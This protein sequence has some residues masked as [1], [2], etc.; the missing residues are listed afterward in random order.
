MIQQKIYEFGPYSLDPVQ[1]LLRRAGSVVPLQPRALEMLLALLKQRGEVVSKQELMERVWPDSFVEEGNLT[2]NIFLLRR[3]LGKTLEGEEYIQTVPK[4]GYRMN[5]PVQESSRNGEMEIPSAGSAG[6]G[7]AETPRIS[8]ATGLAKGTSGTLADWPVLAMLVVLALGIGAI[9]LWQISSAQPKVSGYVRITHDG[10]MKRGK[11]DHVGGP[12]AAL[13]ADGSRIYFM[14]GSADAPIIAEV[15]ATGGETGRLAIPFSLPEL[16]DFSAVGSELLVGGTVDEAS[17]M[18][19]WAVPVPAGTAHRLGAIVAWDASW[20]PDGHEIAYSRG[21]ELYLAK[22]DGSNQKL[23][24]TLP[25]LGWQPRWSPD[26]LRLRFTVFDVPTSITSLWEVSREGTGLHPLL[27][28]WNAG[29]RGDAG[30]V[31]DPISLCCG[32]WTPDGRYFVFQMT[33]EAAR[34]SGRCLANRRSSAVFFRRSPL[35]FGSRAASS[36]PRRP[37]LVPTDGGFSSSASSCA[38]S[39]SGTIT[40]TVSSYLGSAASQRALSTSH[41]MA[42]GSLMLPILKALCG[43]A[44]WMAASSCNSPLLP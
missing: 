12:D 14:E 23:L 41:A 15:S 16:M 19:L 42:S 4:R 28:G 22:S 32:S 30:L 37:F 2:Q 35:R 3:E 5:V 43:A 26:G 9:V 27:P 20:S 36:A 38:G 44:A 7:N 10:S 17:P 8:A 31:D 24:A 18:P 33:G 13:F 25:G 34:T 39:L 40:A 21:R 11:A 1:M 6:T 29:G